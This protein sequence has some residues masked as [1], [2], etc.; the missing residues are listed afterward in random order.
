[1][2]SRWQTLAQT[3][4]KELQVAFDSLTN[5]RL[6]VTFDM[7]NLLPRLIKPESLTYVE[8]KDL[9]TLVELGDGIAIHDFIQRSIDLR[10]G[11][12]QDKLRQKYSDMKVTPTDD[13]ATVSKQ[14]DLKWF[15][16]CHHTLYDVETAH[17]RKEGIREVLTMLLNGPGNIATEAILALT[18]VDSLDCSSTVAAHEYHFQYFIINDQAYPYPRPVRPGR[19]ATAGTG[20][21]DSR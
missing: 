5:A 11:A 19:L 17:G 16:H 7:A 3:P 9:S 10:Y 2:I 8:T 15:L 14:V 21:T 12:V 1:M 18:H 6:K 13:I 20:L 4:P